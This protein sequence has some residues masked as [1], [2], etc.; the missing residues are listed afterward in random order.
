MDIINEAKALKSE[1]IDIRRKIHMRPELGYYD[2]Y[3]RSDNSNELSHND[4]P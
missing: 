4:T 1:V 2:L 3:N